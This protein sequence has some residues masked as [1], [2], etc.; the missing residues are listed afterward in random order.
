MRP[1]RFVVAA[2]TTLAAACVAPLSSAPPPVPAARYDFS[3]A[4]PCDAPGATKLTLAIVAPRWHD[5]AML[6]MGVPA[7]AYPLYNRPRTFLD[8][9]QAMRADFLELA[10][11]RGYLTRGPFDSFDAMVYPDREASQLLLEPELMI[12]V[13]LSNLATVEGSVLT[14]IIRVSAPTYNLSGT[15][16]VAGRV[17]LALKEPI[18]NTRMWTR[19]IEV[20]AEAFD[21]VTANKYPGGITV[22]QAEAVVVNDAGLLRSLIPKLEKMYGSVF[23]TAQSYLDARELATVARQATDVRKKAAIRVP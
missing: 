1:H 18:T 3:P 13:K 12:D 20:P 8:L 21:F 5:Q 19:S 16:T 23:G 6:P 14:Q 2:F 22:P 7:M 11:C 4:S 15:A 10:T 9:A 17:T